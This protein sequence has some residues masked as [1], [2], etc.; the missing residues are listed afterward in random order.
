MLKLKLSNLFNSAFMVILCTACSAQI[1]SNNNPP[2]ND[3]KGLYQSFLN[4]D[5]QK[6]KGGTLLLK[7]N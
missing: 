6:L 7:L 4:S 1:S 5:E 2:S 3:F